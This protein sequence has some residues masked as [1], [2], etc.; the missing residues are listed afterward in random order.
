VELVALGVAAEVVVI[1]QDENLVF[2]SETEAIKMRGGKARLF[3]NPPQG[4]ERTS[5]REWD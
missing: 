3:R 4:T 2:G 5:R 1:V